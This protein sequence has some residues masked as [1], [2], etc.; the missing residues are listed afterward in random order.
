M[1]WIGALAG[2]AISGI[3]SAMSSDKNG[4]AGASSGSKEPWAN[5]QPLLVQAL[6]QAYGHGQR[7]QD[8]PFSPAQQAAYGNSAHMSDYGRQVVPLLLQQLGQQPLGYDKNNP[9]RRPQAF[10]WQSALLANPRRVEGVQAVAPPPPP[11]V[12]AAPV[13][14]AP[15]M[16]E[17]GDMASRIAARIAG[18]TE[19]QAA[20][21]QG[22]YGTYHYGDQ[23]TPQN[24][25]DARMYLLLGGNDP[26]DQLSYLRPRIMGGYSGGDGLA[27]LGGGGMTGPG[28]QGFS[29]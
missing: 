26:K 14:I 6:N 17:G 5:A 27:G 25:T 15:F 7:Y 23:L 12:A 18:Q 13:P 9:G 24:Q 10:D 4:G 19:G 11:P 20:G 28:G 1:A 21:Q 29:I 8:Q 22:Q 2:A 3:G 16:Q